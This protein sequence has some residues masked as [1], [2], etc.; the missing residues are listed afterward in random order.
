MRGMM[1]R[2]SGSAG[3]RHR[4]GGGIRSHGWRCV[5]L[6]AEAELS[7][8]ESALSQH[9][10][11]TDYAQVLVEIAAGGDLGTPAAGVAMLGRSGVKIA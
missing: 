1:A 10:A 2:G 9:I 4:C 3:S 7:A 8:D 11:A 5:S 6:T